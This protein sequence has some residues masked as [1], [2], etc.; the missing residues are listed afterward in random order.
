[1]VERSNVDAQLQSGTRISNMKRTTQD[2]DAPGVSTEEDIRLHSHTDDE[3]DIERRLGAIDSRLGSSPS[4]SGAA[5]DLLGKTINEVSPQDN[6]TETL[7]DLPPDSPGDRP[8]HGTNIEPLFQR[9]S[10]SRSSRGPLESQYV[11]ASER[12]SVSQAP[13]TEKR[14]EPNVGNRT[15]SLDPKERKVS[16][17]EQKKISTEHA[18]STL[19]PHSSNANGGEVFKSI[20]G[21]ASINKRVEVVAD[22]ADRI[23]QLLEAESFIETQPES[24]TVAYHPNAPRLIEDPSREVSSLENRP[25]AA[26]KSQATGNS[27]ISAIKQRAT[28]T[29][30]FEEVSLTASSKTTLNDWTVDS[31]SPADSREVAGGHAVKILPFE[32]APSVDSASASSSAVSSAENL[33]ALVE[34]TNDV[35]VFEDL[36]P[37]SSMFP[38]PTSGNLT[39]VS[40]FPSAELLQDNH[41]PPAAVSNSATVRSETEPLDGTSRLSMF[42]GSPVSTNL[43]SGQVSE[44]RMELGLNDNGSDGRTQQSRKLSWNDHG[45]NEKLVRKGIAGSEVQAF[46]QPGVSAA[47]DVGGTSFGEGVRESEFSDDA[48]RG[49][50]QKQSPINHAKVLLESLRKAETHVADNT[51]HTDIDNE[52]SQARSSAPKTNGGNTAINQHSH[53][54]HIEGELGDDESAFTEIEELQAAVDRVKQTNNSV[55]EASLA[56]IENLRHHQS[57]QIGQLSRLRGERNSAL[58]QVRS[59]Q[60]QLQR[61]SEAHREEVQRRSNAEKESIEEIEK[62]KA[63]RSEVVKI[64]EEAIATQ[65]DLER[66]LAELQEDVRAQ[67]AKSIDVEQF[68]LVQEKFLRAEKELCGANERISG[69]EV[70]MEGR[71]AA[72]DELQEAVEKSLIL[73]REMSEERNRSRIELARL[74]KEAQQAQSQQNEL[75]KLRVEVPRL[76]ALVDTARSSVRNVQADSSREIQQQGQTIQS[77]RSEAATANLQHED[78]KAE[79]TLYREKSEDELFRLRQEISRLRAENEDL[80]RR[81]EEMEQQQNNEEEN[82]ASHDEELESTRQELA[83]RVDDVQELTSNLKELLNEKEQSK[84]K[85]TKMES[86]L[87]CF[88]DE[89]RLRV[90]QLVKHR[91]EAASW[92]ERTVQ[93]N[94]AL[95]ARNSEL[96]LALHQQSRSETGHEQLDS[97][98]QENRNLARANRELS[99]KLDR[100]R[101]EQTA[102]SMRLPRVSGQTPENE[103][104]RT[105]LEQAEELAAYLALS[106]KA[107]L[108]GVSYFDGGGD[109]FELQEKIE[110]LEDAKDEDV[111]GLK[112]RIKALERRMTRGTRTRGRS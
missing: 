52:L 41:V 35:A 91:D 89:T 102:P 33:L 34:E 100:S 82:K 31:N 60:E 45:E 70:E 29:T 73:E 65:A 21:A 7:Y 32:H 27:S 5:H 46:V 42:E 111:F 69:F 66:R 6:A 95:T 92:L 59:L 25:Q 96:E 51:F 62:V 8:A 11:N 109:Y 80:R 86:S 48:N 110:A 79:S 50:G 64:A 4:F 37:K 67:E 101:S 84:S 106:T 88:R 83:R 13:T 1:M 26:E 71:D 63:E 58:R 105:D 16:F 99:S 23:A 76:Q 87:S 3:D 57:S 40:S 98:A 28:D 20:Q 15:V 78:L 24:P 17:A 108:D 53:V 55:W 47:F 68:Q 112:S 12:I 94:Q 90:E 36:K 97:L 39:S 77:L 61:E 19:I 72:I 85:M 2:N 18:A 56:S 14:K 10:R 107:R 81:L 49:T 30:T 54:S 75:A 104:R 38:H 103:T 43:E 74:S 9:K 93:E 44:T 22:S